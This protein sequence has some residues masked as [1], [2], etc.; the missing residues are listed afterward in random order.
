MV[1]LILGR[2][3]MYNMPLVLRNNHQYVL[4]VQYAHDIMNSEALGRWEHIAEKAS[5]RMRRVEQHHVQ[6]FMDYIVSSWHHVVGV[7][8]A[9][10]RIAILLL[11]PRQGPIRSPSAL[12]SSILQPGDLQ[13]LARTVVIN[14]PANRHTV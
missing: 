1:G 9:Y 3:C 10:M 5:G 14:A 6:R 7:L 2:C 13:H 12:S 11:R 8:S 4:L